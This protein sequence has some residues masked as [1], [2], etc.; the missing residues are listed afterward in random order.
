MIVV[1]ASR[2]EGGKSPGFGL[3]SQSDYVEF[4]ELPKLVRNFMEQRFGFACP[5]WF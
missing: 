4:E 1:N 2:F 3:N 5:V